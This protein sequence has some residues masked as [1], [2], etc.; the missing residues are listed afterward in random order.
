MTKRKPGLKDPKDMPISEIHLP[1]WVRNLPRD[2]RE[3]RERR[4]RVIKAVEEAPL[5]NNERA[6]F[7]LVKNPYALVGNRAVTYPN[8]KKRNCLRCQTPFQS[9]HAGHR[10]CGSCDAVN[11]R[12]G[13][14]SSH[15][16]L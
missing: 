16:P 6:F 8:K 2:T 14:F 9:F 4:D 1:P 5:T 15:A 11:A 12:Q 13:G 10:L 3:Q 7:D